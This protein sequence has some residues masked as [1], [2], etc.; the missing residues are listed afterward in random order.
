MPPPP[1]RVRL[2]SHL[3]AGLGRYRW[4]CEQASRR[5]GGAAGG[6]R[7]LPVSI[8]LINVAIEC[9]GA[10][11]ARVEARSPRKLVGRAGIPAGDPQLTLAAIELPQARP[12]TQATFVRLFASSG[13][14]SS[15]NAAGQRG[16]AQ[17]GASRCAGQ[18]RREPT[19]PALP[20]GPNT[21]PPAL[22]AVGPCM[23]PIA[24]LCPSGLTSTTRTNRRPHRDAPR[25]GRP[26]S[27]GGGG[28]RPAAVVHSFSRLTAASLA[29]ALLCCCRPNPKHHPGRHVPQQRAG[30]PLDERLRA[31]AACSHV[32]RF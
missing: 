13:A 3:V 26:T 21:K 29:A 8:Y 6:Q 32:A 18:P 17:S 12:S 19:L 7:A 9:L 20:A 5:L 1:E 31:R 15:S 16:P 23:A 2:R 28:W 30:V 4:L 11:G 24:P 22:I 10:A 27:S 25:R 14:P